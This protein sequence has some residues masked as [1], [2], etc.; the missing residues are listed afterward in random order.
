MES[1]S[2]QMGEGPYFYIF[3]DFSRANTRC[4]KWKFRHAGIRLKEQ[5]MIYHQKKYKMINGCSILNSGRK[6]SGMV[7]RPISSIAN[8]NLVTKC[9]GIL[10]IA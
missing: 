6:N 8:T 10:S 2:I 7:Y 1:K 9:N 5:K 3:T 4:S